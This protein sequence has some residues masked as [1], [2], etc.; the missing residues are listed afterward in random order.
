MAKIHVP[1]LKRR[2]GHFRFEP[3]RSLRARGVAGITLRAADGRF[4]DEQE[5]VIACRVLY[6][7]A[8]T[9]KAAAPPEHPRTVKAMFDA[10][11]ASPK[12]KDTEG[13][14]MKRAGKRLAPRT[15]AGYLA[16]LKVIEA[17]CGDIPAA[18]VTPEDVQI[19]YDDQCEARGLAM[20]N[21]MM[22]TFK[23]AYNHAI[24]K[25]RW[26]LDNPVSAIETG[27]T[28]GRLVIM[29]RDE[30]DALV[31]A[32]DWLAENFPDMAS[33]GDAVVLG[34]F[35]GQRQGDV[36]ATPPLAL[37]NGAYVF[38]TSKT[39]RRAFVP[40]VGPLTQRL[41]AMAARRTARWPNV[42][43]STEIVD[44]KGR[45][46]PERVRDFREAFW[47]LRAIASGTIASLEDG[48][49]ALYGT[50]V[51]LRNTQAFTPQPGLA[52]KWF[53]DLRDT[54][55]TMLAGAGCTVFEIANITG[56]SLKTVSDILDKHYF[57]RNEEL[58]ASAGAKMDA[59]LTKRRS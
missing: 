11:R 52:G 50:P 6:Q 24:K 26:S 53:S 58:A 27:D 38:Q 55:V 36:L 29:S 33:V 32:A 17:W 1:Y 9:G 59:M 31:S 30:I 56:H 2:N 23:L 35:T 48:L 37:V 4:L 43:F 15:R 16:H 14:D 41:E 7:A 5:A 18:A 51:R 22:R 28:E 45:A 49:R 57:V 39:G 8:I 46:W 34:A 47:M 3:G 20:A 44:A 12:F 42:K 13:V 10:L 19:F 54:A 40:P 25:L 21:A